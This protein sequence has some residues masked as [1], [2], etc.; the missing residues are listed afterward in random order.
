VGG[1]VRAVAIIGLPYEPKHVEHNYDALLERI[2]PRARRLSWSA[3][4]PSR[5]ADTSSRT[6]VR[7]PPRA[8]PHSAPAATGDALPD[9]QHGWHREREQDLPRG[10]ASV[11]TG[12]SMVSGTILCLS[13]RPGWTVVP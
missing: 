11:Q 2:L 8:D 4:R 7:R 6:S 13:G 5:C 3:A 12:A 9:R 1:D 10:A